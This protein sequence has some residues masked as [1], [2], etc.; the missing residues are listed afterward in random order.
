M[1]FFAVGTLIEQAAK[2]GEMGVQLAFTLINMEML[3]PNPDPTPTALKLAI[4]IPTGESSVVC[5]MSPPCQATRLGAFGRGFRKS[6]A[7][8][9]PNASRLEPVARDSGPLPLVG[10]GNVVVHNVIV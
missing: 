1:P 2:I 4:S 3:A 9:H 6:P 8:V 10:P 7:A 5:C